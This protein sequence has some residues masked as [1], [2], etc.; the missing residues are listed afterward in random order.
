MRFWQDWQRI[1]PF[2]RG[3]PTTP[4]YG[5]PP[6]LGWIIKVMGTAAWRKFTDDPYGVTS[7]VQARIRQKFETRVQAAI[8]TGKDLDQI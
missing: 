6:G 2:A 1:E 5:A 8:S 3:L 7:T 4:Q